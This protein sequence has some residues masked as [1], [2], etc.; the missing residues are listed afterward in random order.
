[1]SQWSNELQPHTPCYIPLLLD[2][3]PRLRSEGC[4]CVPQ[5]GLEREVGRKSS[6]DWDGSG[7]AKRGDPSALWLCGAEKILILKANKWG[8]RCGGHRPGLRLPM[9]TPE[10]LIQ[11]GTRTS[12]SQYT[13]CCGVRAREKSGRGGRLRAGA[14]DTGPSQRPEGEALVL[15]EAA[16]LG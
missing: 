15:E 2:R 11:R 13:G 12:K 6:R 4:S 5:M 9:S 1:M 10:D 16:R 8:T 3:Q 14:A 7:V